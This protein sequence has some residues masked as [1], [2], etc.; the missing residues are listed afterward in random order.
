ME[1]ENTKVSKAQTVHVGPLRK[2]NI[3]WRT[4]LLCVLGIALVAAIIAGF[5]PGAIPVET[6]RVTHGPLTVNVREEGKTRIRHR[7]VIS[8]PVTGH[9]DRVSLRPGA[10]IHKGTTVLATIKARASDFLTPRNRAETRA[11]LQTASA[12]E[13][14]RSAEVERAQAAR[15]RAQKTFTRTDDLIK[16]GVISRREWDDAES[17]LQILDRELRSARFALRAAAFA[18]EQARATLEEMPVTV[19]E[20]SIPLRIVAPIDGF[21]LN[22]YEENARLVTAGTP[23]MEIGDPRDLEAEVE[24]LSRDAVAVFPGAEVTIEQWGGGFPM[25]GRVTLVEPGGFTKISALGVE[26]QRVKVRVDFLDTLPDGC[27][28]GDRYRVEARIRT[29]HADNVLQ[30]PTGGLFRHGNNWMTF[31]VEEGRAHLRKVEIGHTN[32]HAAE[33]RSGLNPND[34]VVIYP[35]DNMEDGTRIETDS[36][37]L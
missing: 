12:V 36:K 2:K 30:I 24:L 10:R 28:L 21:V 6:A 23:I 26:E 33:V 5:W 19:G 11:R 14:Q 31:V 1:T 35:P 17:R 22:V 29:W 8:P 20:Q 27:R 15:D 3:P 34:Q 25:R 7:Y 18:K 32:G 9:L 13:K 4:M 16:Q 37:N